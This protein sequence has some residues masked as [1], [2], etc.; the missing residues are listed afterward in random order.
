MSKAT[1]PSLGQGPASGLLLIM[2]GCWGLQF[3]MLKLAA[4]G[5]YSDL[6]VLVLAMALLSVVFVALLVLRRELFRLTRER[7]GFLLVTSVLGYLAPLWAALYAASHLPAGILTLMA[8][9]T[10]IATVATA[11]ALRTERVS[12]QRIL[13]V[14]LGAIA[15]CL[16]LGPELELPGYGTFHWLLVALIMPLCYGVESIYIARFWPA[17]LT[18]LQAVTGES[19]MAAL[20]VLPLFVITGGT[21]SW[22]PTWSAAELAIG[23]FVAAG[24]VESLLYFFLIQRTGGVFVTFGGFVSL[25]AGIGWGIV[26][27][28]ETHG[29]H[30]W[31][32][33]AVLCVSLFLAC[34]QRPTS[35][36]D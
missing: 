36:S 10:P 35:P 25:F 23:L 28:S 3:A 18:P 6:A 22:P 2:G 20:L 33:V 19:V 8:S 7:L 24:V 12:V 26:L 13:A 14:I 27:F 5:G 1:S 29:Q 17:G 16:V 9:L 34:W 11:L 30:V 4:G 31:A 21:L 15:V 32:A